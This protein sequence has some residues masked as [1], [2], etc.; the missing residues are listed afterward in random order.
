MAYSVAT[1][2]LRT[3][4]HVGTA[5][6]VVNER[7][8]TVGRAEGAGR[9]VLECTYSGSSVGVA[10]GVATESYKTNGRVASALGIIIERSIAKGVVAQAACGIAKSLKTDSRTETELLEAHGPGCKTVKRLITHSDI[11]TGNGVALKGLP[12]HRDIWTDIE[13]LDVSQSATS[14]VVQERV[15]ANGRIA[16]RRVV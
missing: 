12:P 7:T 16:G 13:P 4:G 9:V 15:R 11:G 6:G 2:C 14:G 5:S 3:N 10:S 1:E 8:S